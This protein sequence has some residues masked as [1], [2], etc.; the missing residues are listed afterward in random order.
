VLIRV[1]PEARIG[2]V[3]LMNGGANMLGVSSYML[4]PLV[5]ELAADPQES[6]PPGASVPAL[7]PV[8]VVPPP[9]PVEAPG[10]EHA[11]TY[12]NG[13]EILVLVHVGGSLKAE[14]GAALPLEV[15]VVGDGILTA[16]IADGREAM[17][18]RMVR[19]REGRVYLLLHGKA[20]LLEG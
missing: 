8:P 18:M 16:H 13:S 6:A 15:R 17:R 7:L 10:P 9:E 12:R 5:A 20:F 14:V 2:I 3:L 11:G 19:D 4:G 1:I